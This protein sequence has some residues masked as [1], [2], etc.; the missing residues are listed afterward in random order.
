[1]RIGI[2]PT[3]DFAFK[4]IFGS[5]ENGAALM[6]L[7][8]AILELPKPI[9]EVEILNPFS[10][11]DFGD[12]K[13][14]ILDIRARDSTG[15]NLNIEMQVS[16]VRSLLPRLVYYACSLYADQLRAG[17]GYNK[18][19]PAISICLLNREL[20]A[21]STEPHHRFRLCDLEHRRELSE[22][23][24]VHTVELPKYDLAVE[25][26]SQR[27]R[28]EQWAFFFLHAADYNRETL[29]A[30][31]PGIE[32]AQAITAIDT[33]S[34][35]TEDKIMYDDRE[36]AQRDYQW[37][38]ESVEEA[39]A[40]G[41]E[42]LREEEERLREE[43]REKGR[44]EGREEGEQRGEWIGKIKLLQELLHET[45]PSKDQLS[46]MTNEALVGLVETLQQRLRDRNGA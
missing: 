13:L 33:I 23:I 29:S 16:V 41:E 17:D 32:F 26:I 2:K 5:P 14:T 30:L 46:Q 18:L 3:V 28:I 37:R 44:E 22:S 25:T 45:P 6:G 21:D 42:R 7:L 11:Q 38:M 20:Y 27:S 8:N 15:R 40:E 12:D 36:K 24:E 43:G 19:R 31:L 35:K 39:L 10:Y 9:R 4:K 34:R 1:M